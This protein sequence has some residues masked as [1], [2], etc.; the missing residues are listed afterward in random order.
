MACTD[1]PLPPDVARRILDAQVPVAVLDADDA[2]VG[3]VERQQVL[4]V[5]IEGLPG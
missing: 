4:D 1:A 3:Y 5:L 2:L